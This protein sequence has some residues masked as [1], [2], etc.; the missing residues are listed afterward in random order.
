[1]VDASFLQRA[2]RER[3]RLL[4]QH[5]GVAFGILAPSASPAQLQQRIQA[6]HTLGHDASEASLAVLAQQL[7]ELEPLQADELSLTVMA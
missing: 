6:R 5:H 7:R 3:F 2:E 4:A 1:V